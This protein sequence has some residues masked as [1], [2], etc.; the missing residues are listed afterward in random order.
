MNV[1]LA[2]EYLVGMSGPLK[3]TGP[4]R[5]P[6]LHWIM[7]E[8]FDGYRALFQY[9]EGRGI[10]LSR[11]G[12]EFTAPAWF[13]EAMPPPN[14]LKDHVLDGE[15]WAG[16]DNFQ[17][18]GTVRKKVPLDEEWMQ[19]QYQVY[20]ITSLENSFIERLKALKR[21]VQ[22]TEK[23]WKGIKSALG[24]PYH[25]LDCPLVFASQT[26]I[27]SLSQM[28]EY[29]ESVVRE[30]G[31]GIM[32]KHPLQPYEHGRSSYLLKYKPVYD[33][34]AIIV[35][36]KAGKGKY[37]S[38]L[39]AF[40]CK[41]LLNHD[42]YSTVDE[43][44]NHVFTL[45]G[46]DDSIRHDYRK[47]HPLGTII[48][49][50]CSGY[51]NKGVPRF[52]R[53]LR[54][55]DDIILKEQGSTRASLDK[56][57][58]I[59]NALETHCEETRDTFRLKSYRKANHCLRQLSEDSQLTDG[60]LSQMEG[61][62][63]GTMEKIRQI[64]ET[65]TCPTYEKLKN[66]V[67][68]HVPKV[69][70][71]KI[72]GVGSVHA[73]KLVKAGFR[74]ID[75]L[76][77]CPTIREHLNEV[78]VKGLLHYEEIQARIPSQEIAQHERLLKSV[79]KEVEGDGAELTIAGS[80]RRNKPDSG[81]I[82]VLVKGSSPKVYQRLIQG[83]LERGYLTCTLAKGAKKYMGMGKLPHLTENRRID[84]MYTKPEEYP[85]AI[86]YFTGSSE[87]NQRMRKELLER[88]LTLNEYS[89]RNSET[90]EKV[91]HT[92]E[93]ERDIFEYLGYAYVEPEDRLE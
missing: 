93:T 84:I 57:M 48:S 67:D 17:L 25:N 85:F 79:L 53:Y 29:Y 16:R 92:F 49:Y 30:G 38:M 80:Y 89:L 75:D 35:E 83:L 82:D 60:T 21:Y 41:P 15:L 13:I 2:K 61:I 10:F 70:F 42:T 9:R 91:A 3:D 50:E 36:Y 81:D 52:G 4:Y 87:F 68:H 7:S 33:R 47:T 76:R 77:A 22:M 56:V 72:H 59:F 64:M 46:M 69:E 8:K 23:R 40:I 54:I 18:M 43:D 62:G 88:G 65:G 90:K 19:I 32:L 51:T 11:S 24:Y 66:T 20:D 74:T 78:Q 14:V 34:E 37:S 12:K 44:P 58:V 26:Q 27:K 39:G 28:K 55:R 6:P 71:M 73:N 45:S 86:L 63:S 1:Q 5:D 31:E